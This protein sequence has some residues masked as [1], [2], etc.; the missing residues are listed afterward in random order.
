MDYY[1]EQPLLLRVDQADFKETGFKT[2]AK[3]YKLYK[4]TRLKQTM[5][6][7]KV[8]PTDWSSTS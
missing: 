4:K 8:L 1:H 2:N 3:E 6:G 5:N 7:M